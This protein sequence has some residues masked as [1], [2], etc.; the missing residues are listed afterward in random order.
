MKKLF[1]SVLSV[2][3]FLCLFTVAGATVIGFDDIFV[4]PQPHTKPQGAQLIM[5]PHAGF[6]WGIEP[7]AVVKNLINPGQLPSQATTSGDYALANQYED[8]VFT[9]TTL[10]GG[11]NFL[12]TI[13]TRIDTLM[14]TTLKTTPNYGYSG[15]GDVT[16]TPDPEPTPSLLFGFGL[17]LIALAGFN[18]KTR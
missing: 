16:Y 12:S 13:S 11:F 14:N 15:M 18:W 17:G 3:V 8:S 5:S 2:L 6:D 10:D 9:A 4:A 7:E 1:L